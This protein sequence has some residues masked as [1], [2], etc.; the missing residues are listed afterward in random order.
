MSQPALFE[1][2]TIRNVTVRNRIW[3]APMCQYSCFN[4]DGIVGDWHM[5]H[6]GSFAIGGAG[7][8]MAEATGVTPE[9]RI[10]P[11]CPGLWN[12]EQI[13][14][15]KRVVDFIASRGAVPGIQLA[16]AG[17]KGSDSPPFD[18]EG[19]S[20]TVPIT[21]GGWK[22][23][24]PSAIAYPG[25]DVPHEL[26]IAEIQVIV[27]AWASAARRAVAAGFRV[28]EIHAAHGYLLHEFLSPLSNQR[29][30][31]YG[32]PL[33]NRARLL[34]EIVSAMRAEM[35]DDIPLFIRFSATDWT[36]GG[37][38]EQETSI[39]ADWARE[40]GADLA[41]IS[42]GGNV[43]GIKISVG[44]GYQVPLAMHVKEHS[45]MPVSTVG[46]ITEPQLANEIV[47]SGKADAVLIGREMLRDPHFALRAAIK[48]G[49]DISYWPGQYEW[50]RP[51]KA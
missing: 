19:K 29:T 10:T 39:V 18:Y 9:G 5:A 37:W 36:E 1:P 46:L 22:S 12:D 15:W 25:H 21:A 34:L 4:E 24:A 44:P 49:A 6:L 38:N 31:K 35:G 50:A 30:D 42:S 23:V 40:R 7:L 26:T 33:E 8:V 16:H 32:G 45:K 41:D 28:I 17:R 2:F 20:G 47:E 14:A 43:S 3:V 13:A 27:D 48:L 11:R 51:R